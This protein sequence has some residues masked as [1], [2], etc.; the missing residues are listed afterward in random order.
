MSA[1]TQ[2]VGTPTLTLDYSGQAPQADG[3][4]YA[5]IVD[6]D[7]EPGRRARS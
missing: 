1:A 3:R 7:E 4:I 6:T 2:L 5:Q